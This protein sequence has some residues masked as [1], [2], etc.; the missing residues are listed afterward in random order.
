M[1]LYNV[2]YTLHLLHDVFIRSLLIRVQG[3]NMWPNGLS[4]IG[5]VFRMNL[6]IELHRNR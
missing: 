1:L 6:C 4:K 3:R 2:I 5:V